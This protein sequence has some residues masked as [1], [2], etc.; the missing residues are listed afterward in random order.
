MEDRE[1]RRTVHPGQLPDRPEDVDDVA[2]V[3]VGRRLVQ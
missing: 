2:D 1:N 3:Q